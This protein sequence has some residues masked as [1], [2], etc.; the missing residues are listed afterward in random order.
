MRSTGHQSGLDERLAVWSQGWA[1]EQ[2]S[3]SEQSQR[4]QVACL[5][6]SIP[7]VFAGFLEEEQ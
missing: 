6:W 2:R 5:P 4:S 7:K 3:N 1:R